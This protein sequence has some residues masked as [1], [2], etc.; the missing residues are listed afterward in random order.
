ML[1]LFKIWTIA[2][3]ETKTL[4]R[5]WF[6]R[7]FSLL[8]IGI[9]IFLDIFLFIMTRTASWSLR[10]IPSSIPYMNLLLLNV[11]QAVIG[12]FM[13]SDFLKYDKKLDSTEVIYM[14][15]MT[16]ADY[17]LGKSIGILLLLLSLN[18]VIIIVTL[19]FNVFFT[20]VSVV[21]ASYL[22]YPIFISIP[23]LIFI[24]GLSFFCMSLLHSQALTFIVL[25]GYITTTLFFLGH[26]FHYLF[27]YMAYN[28]PMM[29]SD[30]V[31]FGNVE[32]LLI[33]RGIYLLLGLGFIFATVLLI[34]RLPQSIIMN[35]ISL[36]LAIACIGGAI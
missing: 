24:F 31:G 14:R 28:V 23:T 32:T 1:S 17:V 3:Y 35:R 4:L 30:F 25:L 19:V 8:A 29:Y 5:S 36:I 9:I 22:Y 2:L 10:G 11:V 33:H 7:I 6:F 20:D 27:D 15:S 34:K 26:K 18:I 12:I 16:N 21:P 13:A